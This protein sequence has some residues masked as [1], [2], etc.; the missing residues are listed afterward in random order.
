MFISSKLVAVACAVVLCTAF[1]VAVARDAS[2]Q[3]RMF[4]RE[5]RLGAASASAS[6]SASATARAAVVQT[7][8]SFECGQH[9]DKRIVGWSKDY[10]E[11]LLVPNKTSHTDDED[12]DMWRRDENDTDARGDGDWSTRPIGRDSTGRW[13]R[14]R[15]SRRDARRRTTTSSSTSASDD[16]MLRDFVTK[17]SVLTYRGNLPIAGTYK[18]LQQIRDF[19]YKTMATREY[20]SIR[21]FVEQFDEVRNTIVLRM[22]NTGRFFQTGKEVKLAIFYVVLSFETGFLHRPNSSKNDAFGWR[23]LETLINEDPSTDVALT[24]ASQSRAERNFRNFATTFMK[25]GCV[26]NMT[27]NWIADDIELEI[28]VSPSWFLKSSNTWKGK[29]KMLEFLMAPTASYIGGIRGLFL[30]D[31]DL[32]NFVQKMPDSA[33]MGKHAHNIETSPS[34]RILGSDDNT[35]SVMKRFY[36]WPTATL[37]TIKELDVWWQITF[38]A[39]GLIQKWKAGIANTLQPWEV[40]PKAL[41]EF[42]QGF[43]AQA[44]RSEGHPILAMRSRDEL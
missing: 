17:R 16:L 18:G 11:Y 40:Y 1:S 31:K 27:A 10:L 26:S 36:N 32:L 35:I 5:E 37:S 42:V 21:L 38:N 29:D 4:V 43:L 22:E 39:D 25:Y 20:S 30:M 41:A 12:F 13:R 34:V 33:F 23:V 28:K 6:T 24:E 7:E 8:F 15:A 2:T 14:T 9:C 3:P 44:G 19:V